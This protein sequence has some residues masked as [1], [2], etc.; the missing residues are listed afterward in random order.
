MP[1]ANTG[2]NFTHVVVMGDI[3]ESQKALSVSMLHLDLNDAVDRA[4]SEFAL[5]SP[6]T[7]TLG[8]EFQG[9]CGSLSDGLTIVRWMRST[10]LHQG[11][12]CR[13]VLGLVQIETAVN[14]KIAWNMMGPGLAEARE[15]LSDKRNASAYRFS[16]PLDPTLQTLLD[17]LGASVTEVEN[18]WTERQTQVVDAS[19]KHTAKDT[20]LANDLG[21]AIR[22]LYKIRRAAR[23]EFYVDQ[24]RA[25]NAALTDL[26]IRYELQ[27]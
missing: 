25:V 2:L 7:I 8:D 27:T 21:L 19:L 11:V 9:L 26:D 5:A 15:R 16:L 13:F 1:L 20:D 17:A 18:S 10:L 14:D 3:I 24:W 12:R 6:L 23:Y 4:N 22:T